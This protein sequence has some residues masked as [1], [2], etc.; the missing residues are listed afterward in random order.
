MRKTLFAIC[1]GLLGM[2]HAQ[3]K[4]KPGI[5]CVW[6]THSEPTAD[7]VTICWM[8]PEPGESRLK[9]ALEG[10][11][12]KEI[13]VEGERTLHQVK[14]PITLGTKRYQYQVFTGDKSSVP[15]RFKQYP[16]LREPGTEMRIVIIGNR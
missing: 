4:P 16:D 9:I 14:V 8:S 2:L 1:M 6:L 15:R 3:E 10:E 11:P 13:V 12:E 5:D 7:S